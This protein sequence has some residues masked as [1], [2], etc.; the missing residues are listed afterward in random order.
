MLQIFYGLKSAEKGTE[1]K[2]LRRSFICCRVMCDQ[3][4]D[5]VSGEQ[6]ISGE[7]EGE[8]E[9]GHQPDEENQAKEDGGNCN[10]PDEENVAKEEREP[11]NEESGGEGVQVKER[12]AS[13]HT[14]R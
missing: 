5:D 13:G 6:I 14:A 12:Q 9:E 3:K 10:Q 8:G 4:S 1:F 2:R 11:I 7:E